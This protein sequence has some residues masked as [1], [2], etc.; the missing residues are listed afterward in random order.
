MKKGQKI[1]M[2]VAGV[3]GLGA[4]FLFASMN[5]KETVV[6]QPDTPSI[7][8][9][10]VLVASKEI[11]LGEITTGATF[12]WQEWPEGALGQGY[13]VEGRGKNIKDFEKR[14]ARVP[15]LAGEP[16]TEVKLVKA[17]EGG[18]MSAILPAGMRAIST[19]IEEKTAAGKL[20][21]PNDFVDVILI[22]RKRGRNGGAEEF[23]SDTLFRNVR[24]LAVGQIIET[25]EGKRTAEGQTATLE[26]TPRQAELLA[27]ANSMGEISLSLRSIADANTAVGTGDRK[28]ESGNSIRVMRYGAKSRAYGVGGN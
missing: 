24:I 27:L 26:L 3:C 11:G 9:T 10:K 22:Q 2:A 21:L 16:I 17:G 4:V 1:G 6:Q 14:I 18:V 20:I 12:R 7:R 23:V 19:R 28:R 15:L 13:V 25:K 5:R 8:S